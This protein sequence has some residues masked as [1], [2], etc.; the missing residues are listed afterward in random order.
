MAFEFKILA[1]AVVPD[2]TSITISDVSEWAESA[3]PRADFALF[4]KGEFRIAADPTEAEIVSDDPEIVID[5][6][7]LTPA[8]G[9]YSY[10]GYGFFIQGTVGQDPIEGD[11]QYNA[12]EDK[13]Q[14]YLSAAWVDILLDDAIAAG[15]QEIITAVLEVPHL[16][17][18]YIQ[19]N[20]MNL[21]YVKQVKRDLDNGASQNKLYYKRVDM[22]YFTS[23]INSAEYSWALTAYSDYYSIVENLTLIIE[24][25]EL[26]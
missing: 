23:L 8:D 5:W 7:A 1:T 16:T 25:G 6:S 15:K 13:L 4:L 12:T 26:S 21:E 18:A 22:D 14:Q 17:N 10:T 24:T 9:R 11:V 2:G 20:L 19:R 3:N